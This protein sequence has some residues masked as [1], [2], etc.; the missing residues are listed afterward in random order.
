MDIRPQ[1]LRK[2]G[3]CPRILQT[4]RMTGYLPLQDWELICYRLDDINSDLLYDS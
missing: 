1:C 3:I 4:L 2:L